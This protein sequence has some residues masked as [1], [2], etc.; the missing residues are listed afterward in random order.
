MH[1]MKKKINIVDCPS[2]DMTENILTKPVTKFGILKF[3]SFLL[4]N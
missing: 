1:S 3:K 4:G 2:E